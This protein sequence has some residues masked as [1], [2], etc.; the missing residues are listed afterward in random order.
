VDAEILS[1]G[2]EI[3]SG[4]LLDTNAQWLAVRLE[5]SGV[6]VLYHTAVGDELEPCARVFR[7]A[8]ER[9]DVVISTGGLGPTA[10]DLT[11]PALARALGRELVLDPDALEGIR[12]LFARRRRE[13]PPSNERQAMLPAGGRV[14]HNPHGTAP[15]IELD[16]ARPGR[17]A[18]RV[19]ALPGVPAELKE[20]WRESV[21]PS[22][23][24]L[25]AGRRV[26]RHKRINCFGA[27]ESQVEAMLPDL[28][29][30]GR[31]PRV[32]I[33]A[34]QTTIILRVTAEGPT[35]EAC[36]AAMAPTVATIRKSL[37][38]LVFGEDDEELQDAVVRLLDEHGLT[39]AA[40][41]SGTSGMVTEWL[42][43]AEGSAGRFLGGAVGSS[44]AALIRALGG[45]DPLPE[46]LPAAEAGAVR[47]AAE[48]C[49]TVFGAD[50]GL[51]VGEFTRPDPAGDELPGVHL[52]LAA[53]DRVRHTRLPLGLHPAILR[54]YAA[55]QAL[56]LVR[57]ALL[58]RGG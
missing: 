16:V 15:G 51:A 30:R 22:L 17:A 1:I 43:G 3:T 58:E 48:R 19:V 55:K 4:Q 39:L 10:D 56:N 23:C 28:I 14:V 52:A 49:R 24:A 53:A 27:G 12:R 33:N 26:V 13:M 54:T 45:D 2:D 36:R 29:R 41:E 18:C 35:E 42:G 9:A 11:R 32:G 46:R 21:A 8:I 25:G 37:G 50:L 34:S 20:M 6:R 7:S 31:Q 44:A 38:N 47:A 40:A 5:E 57:L